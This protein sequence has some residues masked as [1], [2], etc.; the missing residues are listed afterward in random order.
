[1]RRICIVRHNYYPEEAHVRRDAETLVA[2]GYEVDV[3]CLKKNGQKSR[4]S[5]HGVNIYRLPVEHH[6]RGVPRYLLEYTAFTFIAS[7]VLGWLFLTRRYKVIQV[8][9]MPE[10]LFFTALFPK[11]LGAKVVLYVFDHTPET[12]AGMY[13][14][15]TNNPLIRIMCLLSKVCLSLANY[16]IVP[17]LMNLDI[18]RSRGIPDSKTSLVFNVPDEGVFD[19]SAHPHNNH[20]NFCL[21][22]HGSILEKYGVQTMIRAVPLLTDDIPNL[23]VLIVGEGEYRPRLEELSQS[24]GAEGYVHFTG[25]V[26]FE[27]VSGLIAQADIGVVPVIAPMLPNKLFEYWAMGKPVVIT[28]NT[29]TEACINDGSVIFYEPDNEQDLARC[30]LELYRN[31]DKRAAL[32]ASGSEVYQKYRWPVMKYEYLKV[33]DKLT[34]DKKA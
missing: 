26:P 2:H 32:A 11:I 22:T 17:E 6:R 14:I 21:I 23:K 34:G 29:A 7:L 20:D 16:I 10:T 30:I 5:V 31:P 1:L 33:F 27:E 13:C 15:S 12:F 4:E 19:N 3:I 28:R 25:L 8:I 9:S 18:V 24:L